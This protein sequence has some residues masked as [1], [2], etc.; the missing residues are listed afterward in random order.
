MSL[1]DV[2]IIKLPEN[3]TIAKLN[4]I[5]SS[6]IVNFLNNNLSDNDQMLNIIYDEK[7][8][9][10]MKKNMDDVA[11]I[12]IICDNRILGLCIVE[13]IHFRIHVDTIELPIIRLCCV[14]KKLRNNGLGKITVS[15]AANIL[16]DMNHKRIYFDSEKIIKNDNIERFFAQSSRSIIPLN[17]NRLIKLKLLPEKVNYDISIDE[18]ILTH[19]KIEDIDIVTDKIN[20]K[21]SKYKFRRFYKKKDIE[22][23]LS[24]KECCMTYVNKS[25]NNY[26]TDFI[27][28]RIEKYILEDTIEI[29]TNAHILFYHNEVLTTS[30][31]FSLLMNKL[32]NHKID[33]LTYTNTFENSDIDVTHFESNIVNYSYIIGDL[34]DKL[35]ADEIN[36]DL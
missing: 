32:T 13:I 4:D 24:R 35:D 27:S 19:M 15:I 9:R 14:Y 22:R 25:Y 7:Y 2:K 36:L 6:E 11:S 33:Q 29:I 5:K 21:L 16:S 1:P 8:I 30:E 34:I 12:A 10:W 20:E 23:L 26:I 17:Q 3:T 18:N 31:L 28:V